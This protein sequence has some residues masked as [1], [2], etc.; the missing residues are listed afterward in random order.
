M[1]LRLLRYFVAVVDTGSVTA[2][3]RHVRVAQPSLSRQVRSL[4]RQL[5]LV[6]FDRVEGR[7]TLSSAGQ[8]FLPVARDLLARA[9]LAGRA[10]AAIRDGALTDLTISCPATTLTDVIAPFLATWTADDPM[11]RVWQRL[12][13]QIYPS[14]TSGA[15]LA[16][17]TAPP[18]SSLTSLPLASLPVWAYV[19]PDHPWATRGSVRLA[20]LA[21]QPLLLLGPE[22]HSRQA[23]DAAILG[24]G[25]GLG[26][27]T[28]FATAEVAQAVAAAGR[29]VAIV[30]DDPRFGLVAL[31]VRH[32]R[33][34]LVIR[35]HAAWLADHHASDSLA[36]LARRLNAF[37]ES[38]YAVDV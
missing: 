38:R 16:V 4:E 12:P 22:Q 36:S 8:R 17:G 18:P 19:R 24:A 9:D 30:S 11:P 2:A 21:D 33:R 37:C 20:D 15:D 34:D 6:L 35:L 26:D 3:A 1:D 32:E 5:G 14:L 25:V 31:R 29:G 7:L 27:T 10:A 13:A 28:E 23:L